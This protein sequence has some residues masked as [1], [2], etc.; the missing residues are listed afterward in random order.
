MGLVEL[1]LL[2][3][4][5]ATEV[6]V[7]A[8]ELEVGLNEVDKVDIEASVEVELAELEVAV[9]LDVL[10]VEI[11][12][13]VVCSRLEELKLVVLVE[14]VEVRVVV[15]PP[16]AVAKV[17]IDLAVVLRLKTE[18]ELEALSA[19]MDVVVGFARTVVEEPRADAEVGVGVNFAELE[20]LIEAAEAA[21]FGL[22]D[23]L[24]LPLFDFISCHAPE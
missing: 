4:I 6:L 19:M 11:L 5:V 9:L 8:L 13:V 2:G 20:T 10:E 3:V 12:E 14:G 15:L 22:P 1:G 21:T 7:A 18:G 24:M 23:G 17:V 16:V